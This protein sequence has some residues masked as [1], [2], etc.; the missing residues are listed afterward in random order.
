MEI[1]ISLIA[2][3]LCWIWIESIVV[4]STINNKKIKKNNNLSLNKFRWILRL[5]TIL[6]FFLVIIYM[7]YFENEKLR[8]S[9]SFCL[10]VINIR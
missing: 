2:L 7:F 6:L 4:L 9:I 10:N 3:I 8:N 1:T 5:I